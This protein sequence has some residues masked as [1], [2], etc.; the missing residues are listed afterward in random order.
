[1]SIKFNMDNIIKI[2]PN[3]GAIMMNDDGVSMFSRISDIPS[4]LST[5]EVNGRL[6]VIPLDYRFKEYSRTGEQII[7]SE[8]GILYTRLRDGRIVPFN[9]ELTH[10]VGHTYRSHYISNSAPPILDTDFSTRWYHTSSPIR[11]SDEAHVAK[12]SVMQYVKDVNDTKV[13][14]WV[15]IYPKTVS[16][17]VIIRGMGPAETNYTLSD[18]VDDSERRDDE[19]ENVFSN[20]FRDL[21]NVLNSTSIK[22]TEE[23]I[24]TSGYNVL[25]VG[26]SGVINPKALIDVFIDGM[27][28]ERNMYT[29]SGSNIIMSSPIVVSGAVRIRSTYIQFTGLP[30]I[31]NKRP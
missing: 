25:S 27:L 11:A 5:D 10:V 17:G 15:Y 9:T 20:L 7:D 16:D 6:A 18:F 22:E 4:N 12:Y 23:V 14:R 30:L 2:D 21:N 31:M 28:L 19:T 3:N 26:F 1:M 8:H 13:F 24:I 29:I